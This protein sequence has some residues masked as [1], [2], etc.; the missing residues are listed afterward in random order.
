MPLRRK[1]IAY[2]AT[3][4]DGY[5]ARPDG[6]VEWL[7]RHPHSDAKDM[8]EFYKTIDTILFGRKTFDWIAAYSKKT[9]AKASSFLDRKI[10]NYIFSRKS[11]KK[12]IEGAEWVSEPVKKFAQRLRRA[13]G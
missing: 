1:I 3:S 2:I 8:P 4:A 9:G 12:A 10:A 5:I 13:P 7:N 11:H 6:D